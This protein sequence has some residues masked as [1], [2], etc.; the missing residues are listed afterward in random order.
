MFCHDC[1]YN[2]RFIFTNTKPRI[3]EFQRIKKLQVVHRGV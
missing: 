3:L 1:G 2:K